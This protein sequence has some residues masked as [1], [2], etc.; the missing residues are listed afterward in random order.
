MIKKIKYINY[1]ISDFTSTFGTEIRHLEG[2]RKTKTRPSF[3][4]FYKNISQLAIPR[5]L[6][7]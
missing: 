3:N 4:V 2:S 6:L 5:Q 1:L 7:L